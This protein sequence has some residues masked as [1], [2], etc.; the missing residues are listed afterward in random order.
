MIKPKPEVTPITTLPVTLPQPIADPK[1]PSDGISLSP[2]LTTVT[3]TPT[4]YATTSYLI[5]QRKA[6]NR[7]TPVEESK[8]DTVTINNDHGPLAFPPTVPQHWRSLLIR[9]RTKNH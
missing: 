1:L 2:T 7:I 4:S 6:N 9:Y 3:T 8:H 5:L